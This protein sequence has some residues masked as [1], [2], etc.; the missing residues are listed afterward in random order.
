MKGVIM[1][2][3]FTTIISINNIII[4]ITIEQIRRFVITVMHNNNN[5]NN[6]TTTTTIAQQ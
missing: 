3:F 2:R 4:G 6:N 5:N 1:M